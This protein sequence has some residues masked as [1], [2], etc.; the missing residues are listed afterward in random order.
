M[1][2][3]FTEAE[4]MQMIATQ[5]EEDL[6]LDYKGADSLALTEAKKKEISIIVSSFA[7]SDGGFVIYGIREFDDKAKRHL[8][9]KIDPVDRKII[10]K[11]WL[12]QVISS[13]IQPKINGLTIHPVSLVSADTHVAYV[14]NIPKSNTAHQAVDKKY[15]K[16]YNFESVAMED[17]EIRDI[18]NRQLFPDL[19]LVLSNQIAFNEQILSFPIIIRNKSLRLAK[20]VKMTVEFVDFQNYETRAVNAFKN[21]TDI[22][23]GIKIY[24]TEQKQEVYNGIDAY[25]GL[26]SLTLKENVFRVTIK[27]SIYCDNLSPIVDSFEILIENNVPTYKIIE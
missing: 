9:E 27:T 26:F 17:Y 14:V 1:L 3:D 25:V 18:L 19:E 15:Y 11:E 20:D 16:R 12:E 10:S 21:S 2:K 23:P 6:H 5:V 7:N 8:P 4:L 24:S 13:N 22:N